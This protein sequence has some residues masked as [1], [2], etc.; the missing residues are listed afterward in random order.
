MWY[1]ILFVFLQMYLTH[2]SCVCTT[3]ACPVEGNN[4]IIMGNGG[5]DLTYMYKIHNNYE[6]VVSASGTI[7]PESL[8]NGTGTTSCTQH[9]SRLLEDD[10]EQDCDAGHILANRLGGY[11]NTP[12]N[13]FPQNASINRGTYAQFEGNIYDCMKNGGNIGY[14]S[15]EFYYD[16]DKHT[17][18]NSVKYVAKFEGGTC[19]TISSL[20]SN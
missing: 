4:S 20:F 1:S 19:K 14:L 9:Y 13:I 17:M 2:G 7:T 16:D 12:T 11:G 8:D 3:V 10:G 15:W 5:A 18:P 6:V